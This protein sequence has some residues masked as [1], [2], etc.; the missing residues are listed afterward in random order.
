MNE[1]NR[2]ENSQLEKEKGERALE[3]ADYYPEISFTKT[4]EEERLNEVREFLKV[5][6]QYLAK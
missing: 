6:R 2:I 1:F 3:E 4:I 5:C